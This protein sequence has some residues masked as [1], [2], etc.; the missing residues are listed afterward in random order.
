[1]TVNSSEGAFLYSKPV[2]TEPTHDR[3]H[4]QTPSRPF[5]FSRIVP[6]RVVNH[7]PSICTPLVAL[8]AEILENSRTLSEFYT[9]SSL[10]QPSFDLD[11]AEDYSNDLPDEIQEVRAKLRGAT[12]D[13][14]NLAA[15]PKESIMWMAWGYHDVSLLRFVSHFNIAEAVPLQGTIAV[16]EVSGP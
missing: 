6:S 13:M 4:L 15:G 14:Q 11:G 16:E 8:A 12:A 5:S 9:A 7:N 3:N 2:N 1:M 10:P